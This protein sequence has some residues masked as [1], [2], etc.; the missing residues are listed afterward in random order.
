MNVLF[1]SLDLF[2]YGGIQRYSRYLLAAL[3]R[4][5]EVSSVRVA[6]LAG[7]TRDGFTQPL[8]VDA[9]GH[10]PR[11][12]RKLLFA[13]DALRLA[14]CGRASVV[15]CDHIN[16]APLAYLCA[17][18]AR[19]PYW[20]SV[21]AIEVWGD[22][23]FLRRR[24]LLGASIIV[25]DCDF[26]RRHL[27]ARYP[28]LV[29]RIT[30][31]PD[32]VD[33]DR[34]VPAAEPAMQPPIPMLLTVSRLVPGRSKGHESVLHAMQL[35]RAR[36]VDARYVIAGSGPDRARLESIASTLQL[37]ERVEFRGAVVDADL[38]ALYRECDVFVLVSG[39]ALGE[40]PQGEGV[41]LV[42]LEAQACGKPVITSSLD[43]SAESIV[44]GETGSLV[45]PVDTNALADALEC[46]LR[47]ASLRDRMGAAA[48]RFAVRQ[49]SVDAFERRI[50][51]VIGGLAT[52]QGAAAPLPSVAGVSR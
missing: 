17:R 33:I 2:S 26:T 18:V 15:I 13:L 36:G 25:S 34:F 27:E 10:G 41:P 35:L 5:S 52:T 45:D 23:S 43:G 48:R 46:M 49:F 20:L 1:L 29:G 51:D 44:D 32:C 9:I 38:P 6:S 50:G 22:L 4:S 11:A 16:L 28:V 42:V 37:G 39:F 47:D 31:V 7:D 19:K 3:R 24:A 40:H 12:L 8:E 14:R 21:Y 30:V